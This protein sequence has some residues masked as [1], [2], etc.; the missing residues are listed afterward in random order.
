MNVIVWS[1]LLTKS[2]VVSTKKNNRQMLTT[3]QLNQSVFTLD[4]RKIQWEW[5]VSQANFQLPWLTLKSLSLS[6]IFF[7]FWEIPQQSNK[8]TSK[9]RK[10]NM[11]TY[12]SPAAL[13]NVHVC[14]RRSLLGVINNG[15]E[16]EVV[17]YFSTVVLED[18]CWVLHQ[19]NWEPL[20]LFLQ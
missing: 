12:W 16:D 11:W 18:S 2:T 9:Y 3:G 20:Q 19:L 7:L 4:K 15:E 1:A 10:F 14:M 6:M 13:K 8:L 17:I 5:K